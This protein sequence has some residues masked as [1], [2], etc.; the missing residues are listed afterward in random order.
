MG[1]SALAAILLGG[2]AG[3]GGGGGSL[4]SPSG[5]GTLRW[6]GSLK[7][8]TQRKG[9]LGMADQA[10]AFGT[11]MLTRS[12]SDPE[13]TDVRITISTPASAAGNFLP[14][15]MLPGRCGSGAVP[16]MSLEQFGQIDVGT[17]SRGELRTSLAL[18][19]PESGTYHANVYWPRGSQLSDV[20]TC[21]N[22]ER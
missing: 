15:A 1:L 11:V 12:A 18:P 5:E 22:L 10:R 14:W 2:C 13:R 20:M 21:A 17:N 4:P 6:S 19:L 8:T 16:L 9:D 7:P 3:Q